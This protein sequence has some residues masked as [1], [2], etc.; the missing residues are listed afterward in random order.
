MKV[1]LDTSELWAEVCDQS[2][3]EGG[4]MGRMKKKLHQQKV[5]FLCGLE[6]PLKTGKEGL[7]GG[8]G[9]GKLV[10]VQS[11]EIQ[12]DV[13]GRYGLEKGW[14]CQFPPL[15]L[16]LMAVCVLK[17]GSIRWVGV[18]YEYARA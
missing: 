18:R 3:S 4:M 14:P 13:G 16:L 5:S 9:G 11:L 17:G 7:K 1:R 6:I 10:L 12:Q 8:N 15:S 2:G